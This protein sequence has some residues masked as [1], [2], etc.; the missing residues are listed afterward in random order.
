MLLDLENSFRV[1]RVFR[2]L[3]YKFWY[4]KRETVKAKAFAVSLFVSTLL[5]FISLM[6]SK[7]N[8]MEDIHYQIHIFGGIL[9]ASVDF[10]LF[11]GVD[12]IPSFK[13]LS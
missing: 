5:F 9:K 8:P 13:K 4:K 10:A 12:G 6:Q 3:F 1:F 2:G 7:D 11:H